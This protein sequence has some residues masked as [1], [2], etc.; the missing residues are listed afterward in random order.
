MPISQVVSGVAE[1]HPG[2][3]AQ[4]I[5]ASQNGFPVRIDPLAGIDA[6]LGGQD[7][8]NG[9]VLGQGHGELQESRNG[10]QSDQDEKGEAWHGFSVSGACEG[11]ST[12]QHG[13][14]RAKRFK[15]Q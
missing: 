4:G 13:Q 6:D 7:Q 14:C 5:G 15:A 12:D 1:C 11:S 9:G 10:Q 8:Q 3:V 2:P